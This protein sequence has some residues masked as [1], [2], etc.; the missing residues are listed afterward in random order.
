MTPWEWLQ[1][2]NT[3]VGL[4]VVIFLLLVL[5]FALLLFWLNRKGTELLE[6]QEEEDS[7]IPP[8]DQALMSMSK[9]EAKARG[10]EQ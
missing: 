10:I 4:G 1:A 6:H 5:G 3:A 9:E 8:L 2:N 7:T